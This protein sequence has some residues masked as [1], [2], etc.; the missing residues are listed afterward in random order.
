MRRVLL[1]VPAK[2]FEFEPL[3]ERLL[4]L[5]GK[6][7]DAFA[8]RALELD[9]IV[10]RHRFGLWRIAYSSLDKYNLLYAICY[11]LKG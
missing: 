2:L 6:I 4:I 11:W 1:A 10:L 3:P 8:H 9:Q 7:G 5:V